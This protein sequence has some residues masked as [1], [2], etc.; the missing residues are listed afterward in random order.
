MT[1]GSPGT[2]IEG[3]LH[4]MTLEEK[5]G[6]LTMI[7]GGGGMGGAN[8]TDAQLGH[9]RAGRAGSVLDLTTADGIRRAQ[10]A[11]IRESRLGIPLLVCLDVLHGHETIFPIPLGEAAAFDPVLWEATARAAAEEAAAAHVALTFAP[12]LDIARD[13]RWGRMAESPGEDPWLG[14]RFAEAKVR[15]FQQGFSGLGTLAATAKHLGAYGAVTAGREYNSVDISA[16]SLHEVYLPPFAAAVRAGVAA[17]MPAFTDLA[18]VPMTA[19]AAILRTILRDRW[20]FDGVI[21][22]DFNAIAEL[23]VHGIAADL[24]EAAA[25]A[26][27]A[28]VDVDMVSD[29]YPK[30][31]PIA[32]ERGLI[33]E[34]RIDEAVSRVL[35]LKVRLGLFDD[36]FRPVSGSAQPL[37]RELARDV[38]RRSI[39]LLQNRGDVLPL[40]GGARTLAVIG[41]FAAAEQEMLGPWYGLGKAAD[42]KSFLT[43]IRDVLPGWR[44]THER[45][46]GITEDDPG[47]FAGAL[48]AAG[49]ADLILL[50]LGEAAS[51]CGEAASRAHPD[52]P[53][54]QR[55]LA[56]AIFALNKPVIVA[57]GSGRPLIVPWLFEKA[58]A[59]LATWFLGSEA[60]TAL[61]DILTGHWNP[62]GKLP[63]SWPADAG[64]IP[65]FYAQRPTGR[66]AKPGD[67][68]T[69]S[70]L[71]APVEPHFPFG[72][73]LSYT[74]FEYR[75]L[76]Y[77]QGTIM[78][79]QSVVIEADIVN[80]GP[81]A[82]EETALLFIRDPVASVARPVLEL[83]GVAK[84]TLAPG[85][86][87]TARFELGC[88][89]LSFPDETG[90]MV[91]EPGTIE[92]LVGPRAERNAL[93][94]GAIE[95]RM[96]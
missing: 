51:M 80:H 53:Q 30:G 83:K 56:E 32:L 37:R 49:E 58:D 92:I 35:G 8:L 38:A 4:I 59:V 22:S 61:A 71:D 73:G 54:C 10:E 63:V 40:G 21:I 57:L 41:P 76:R 47:S 52:L 89:D 87:G 62:S 94:A 48:K 25:L 45:G 81:F 17:I 28:G 16:R 96:A 88:E 2:R 5:I 20:G 55:K 24:A 6:Q 36:P 91:L 46:A 29:A 50:C 19:N 13:P 34:A 39:V 72:H 65:I 18:G 75:A 1:F 27:K 3:L 69:S 14:A 95:L 26:M 23:I 9:V 93:L 44:I 7:R 15:G 11:A 42:A 31:L 77:S 74:R 70:Y 86:A 79:G 64:Q 84:V 82:G 33:E 43:G 68:F 67:R 85:A 66:P 12:M 78:P 60:G 90:T